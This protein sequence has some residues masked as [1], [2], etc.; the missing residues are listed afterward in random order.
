MPSIRFLP[1]WLGIFAVLGFSECSDTPKPHELRAMG[2]QLEIVYFQPEGSL[3]VWKLAPLS[4]D[5]L[6]CYPTG[7][8]LAALLCA[9]YEKHF[10]WST[11]EAAVPLEGSLA[12]HAAEIRGLGFDGQVYGVFA[13]AIG[14]AAWLPEKRIKTLQGYVDEATYT[15]QNPDVTIGYLHPVFVMSPDNREFLVY[16]V[17]GVQKLDTGYPRNVHDFRRSEFTFKHA[18]NLMKPG[19]T[20]AERKQLALKADRMDPDQAL[21]LW[22]ADDAARLRAD[23]AED[24]QQI[25]QGLRAMLSAEIKMPGD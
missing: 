3:T 13:S 8:I 4:S 14:A 20:V 21:A 7:G 25:D 16:A 15:R 11:R 19:M 5:G 24:L 18:L 6:G 12:Q 1:H 17:A 22:L 10:D 23:V 9:E 2:P